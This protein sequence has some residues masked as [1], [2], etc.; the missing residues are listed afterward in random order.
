MT[1]SPGERSVT[2][3]EP[4]LRQDPLVWQY[5]GT[6]TGLQGLGL[7]SGQHLG[8]NHALNNCHD[9]MT[10]YKQKYSNINIVDQL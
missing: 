7:S 5:M 2:Y 1:S 8:H 6:A 4:V 10:N 3:L 9:S